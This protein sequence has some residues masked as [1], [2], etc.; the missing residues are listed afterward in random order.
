MPQPVSY[1]LCDFC[2]KPHKTQ[3][4]ENVKITYKKCAD[5]SVTLQPTT[6]H[7]T[8]PLMNPRKVTANPLNQN[9]MPTKKIASAMVPPE[10]M[11]L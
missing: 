10:G 1:S 2:H 7:I 5:C 4:L 3:E 8:E 9:Y 11:K 6:E